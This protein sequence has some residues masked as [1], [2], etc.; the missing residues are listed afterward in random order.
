MKFIIDKYLYLNILFLFC[1]IIISCESPNEVDPPKENL[2]SVNVSVNDSIIYLG[3]TLQISLHVETGNLFNGSISF[4]DS[5]SVTFMNQKTILDTTIKHI[6]TSTGNYKVTLSISDGNELAL[7]EF[8]IEVIPNPLFF[9]ILAVNKTTV[10]INYDTLIV[11]LKASDSTL[12]H[13]FLDFKDGTIV[14]FTNLNQTFD[15]TISHVYDITS[16][17]GLNIEASFS[18]RNNK[19]IS[20]EMYINIITNPSPGVSWEFNRVDLECGDTLLVHLYAI[21]PSLSDGFIDFKDGTI[22]SFTRSNYYFNSNIYVL[23]TTITHIYSQPGEYLVA[24]SFTDGTSTTTKEIKFLIPLINIT[25]NNTNFIL[26]DTIKVNLRSSSS[27]L[28]NGTLDFKDGTIIYFSNITQNFDTT[29]SYVYSQPGEY[30][31]T[32]V[33]SNGNITLNFSSNIKVGRYFELS[34]LVGMKWIYKYDYLHSQNFGGFTRIRGIHKWEVTSASNSIFQIVEITEDTVNSHY[35]YG[36]TTYIK[37]DTT[38]F[39]ISETYDNIVFDIP[40]NEAPFTVPNH[41]L[42][43]SYPVKISKG[44]DS[45]IWCEDVKGLTKYQH[46]RFFYYYRITINLTLVEFTMP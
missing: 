20:K 6:Y 12:S 37:S 42:V 9:V 7:K 14:S 38:I 41:S 33:F 15:T 35:L 4:G 3:D 2:I 1:V 28:V 19:T 44:E 11:T 39:N 23:D 16:Y 36:D 21:D 40:Y 32:A 5:N 34:F 10:V 46:D 8:N 22:I 26:G 18:N 43:Y 30:L 25:L 45:F 17:G 13:G 27:T 29:I 24:T 31:F